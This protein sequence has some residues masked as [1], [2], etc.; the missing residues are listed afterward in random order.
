MSLGILMQQGHWNKATYVLNLGCLLKPV[1]CIWLVS[2]FHEAIG[3]SDL[4]RGIYC[5]PLGQ[6]VGLAEG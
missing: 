2:I 6:A 3:L 4:G 1:F 5:A